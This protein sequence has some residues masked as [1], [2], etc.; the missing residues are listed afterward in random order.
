M[1]E[2]DAI[3][4]EFEQMVAAVFS[5]EPAPDDRPSETIE[6]DWRDEDGS[7]T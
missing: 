7:E 3:V 4:K 6:Y 2:L 5:A 1:D